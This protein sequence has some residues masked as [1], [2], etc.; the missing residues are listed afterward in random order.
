M[1]N[2]AWSIGV[3]DVQQYW[4]L[5]EDGLLA[6]IDVNILYT[7]FCDSEIAQNNIS[8]K[9]KTLQNARKNLLKKNKSKPVDVLKQKIK[10]I[11]LQIQNIKRNAKKSAREFYQEIAS[12]AVLQFA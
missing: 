5:F 1:S 12:L 11:D 4:N 10:Q 3:P 2:V 8:T 7:K 6:V 9:T